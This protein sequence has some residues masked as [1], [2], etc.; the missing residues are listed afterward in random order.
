M[1]NCGLAFG[2]D[3]GELTQDTGNVFVVLGM[4]VCVRVC[5]FVCVLAFVCPSLRLSLVLSSL[6]VFV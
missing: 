3:A 2:D 1:G 4:C 5:T 6:F